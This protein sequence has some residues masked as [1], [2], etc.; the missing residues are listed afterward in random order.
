MSN[1]QIKQAEPRQQSE[2]TGQAPRL[3]FWAALQYL[4]H[5]WSPQL[6]HPS[7]PREG[8]VHPHIAWL[9]VK[10]AVPGTAVHI[11]QS[12]LELLECLPILANDPAHHI[13]R[14]TQFTELVYNQ[15][16]WRAKKDTKMVC[17]S[18]N[19]IN[20]WV[21]SMFTGSSI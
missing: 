13:Y 5:L 19:K 10:G 21:Y 8:A 9:W 20:K 16:K 17:E 18:I 2:F 15:G 3:C 11:D 12:L 7:W 1:I 14:T 4:Q 6:L